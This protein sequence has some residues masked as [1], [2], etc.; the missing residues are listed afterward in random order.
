MENNFYIT[1]VGGQGVVRL[2]QILALYGL[3]KGKKVRFYKQVGMAQRG[4]PVHCEV[5]IGEV[6]GSRIPPLS[7]DI[8]V[9][10]ELAEGLKALEFVKPGG[11]VILNRK[12]IY[13]LDLMAY[14]DQYPP[15][16]EIIQLFKEVG[17]KIFWIEADR[18]TQ[19]INL[20]LAENIIILGVIANFLSLDKSILLN[21]LEKNVLGSFLTKNLEAFERGFQWAEEMK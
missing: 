16:E 10:M 13:P 8:V 14:P 12:K 6:F 17:A 19:E 20:P 18:I 1:G 2:G 11:M 21:L 3:E 9:V 15:E 7:A 4:G 5:R